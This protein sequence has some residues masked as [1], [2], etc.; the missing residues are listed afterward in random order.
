MIASVLEESLLAY[1]GSAID[2]GG[3]PHLHDESVLA[4]RRC[5]T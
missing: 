3:N 4:S 5:R 2:R 1:V